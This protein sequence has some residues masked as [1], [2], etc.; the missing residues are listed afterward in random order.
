MTFI[1]GLFNILQNNL[2]VLI[3]SSFTGGHSLG[4][5]YM[6][7]EIHALLCLLD[8]DTLIK[9]L[10]GFVIFEQ[11]QHALDVAPVSVTLEQ[12]KEIQG[13]PL[14]IDSL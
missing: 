3:Q 1:F 10:A 5:P 13:S 7:Q 12:L 11:L 2:S 4:L 8:V 9:D 14:L 6:M